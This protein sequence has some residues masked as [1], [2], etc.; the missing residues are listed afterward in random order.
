MENGIQLNPHEA[1]TLKVLDGALDVLER[2]RDTEKRAM[3]EAFSAC[4]G[5]DGMVEVNELELLGVISD[6]FGCQMPSVLVGK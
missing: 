4:I 6:A 3:L 5:A 2:S 1:R